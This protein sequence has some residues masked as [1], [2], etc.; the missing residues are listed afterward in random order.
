MPEKHSPG[1][2]DSGRHDRALIDAAR[3]QV[4]DALER[5]KQR[6]RTPSTDPA[7]QAEPGF[8]GPPTD[9]F[10]GYKI[11]SEIH[12]GGQGVVYQAFQESTKRKVAIKVMKE[13]PFAGSADKARFEREVQILGQL[14]HPN[15][16]TVYDS[17]TAAGSFFFVMDYISGQ[18]LDVYMGSKEHSID[19]TLK[20]FAKICEAVNSAHLK[21]V[22]HRDLKPGN[23]RIDDEGEPH[24]LDFG[25]AK[26]ALTGLAGED[27]HPTLM[28]LTG[29]FI[30]GL[31]GRYVDPRQANRSVKGDVFSPIKIQ[32]NDL[33]GEVGVGV[34]QGQ[35]GQD[36]GN[37][38]VQTIYVR[39]K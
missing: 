31:E 5:Q 27:A 21:G 4:E 33:T 35:A 12:R 22:I 14:K 8:D 9:S 3:G 16:V 6:D 17:G 32:V 18:Q 36:W 25:L 20:L 10:K 13:G 19:E 37:G 23:I 29:Q 11:I 39:R 34:K 1:N 26:V 24:I 30:G 2:E 38:G 7:Q 28:T 15:I